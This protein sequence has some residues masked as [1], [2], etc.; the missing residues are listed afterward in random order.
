MR[1][2]A[3]PM[4]LLFMTLLALAAALPGCVDNLDGKT[5]AETEQALGGYQ[6][7]SAETPVSTQADKQ[8]S[9]A[10]PTGTKAIGAG[11]GVLDATGANLDGIASYF[12]PSFDGASWLVNAKN[13]SSYASSWKL[14]VRVIC[15]SATL[16]GYEVAIA[17]TALTTA[18][19]KQ[20]A[21]ACPIG[22]LSLGAGWSVLDSTNGILE[23][24]A[25]HFAPSFDGGSWLVRARNHSSF[26]PSWKLQ[27]RLIC[28]D[29]SAVAGYQ[30]VAAETPADTAGV[31]QLNASCASGTNATSLGWAVLDSTSAILDGA[32]LYSLPSFDGSSWLTN[33]RNHSS[34]SPTW[35][36]RVRAICTL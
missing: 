2:P 8:L 36:L 29:A 15:G 28:V 12:A 25:L 31:K 6:V 19:I 33:A 14:R 30:V 18:A 9:V 24:E 22:K 5:V 11:W 7:V 23:G 34:F 3:M 35:K 20:L 10:C 27:T 17:D 1:P 13:T 26:S 21:P 4:R 32:A 16:A